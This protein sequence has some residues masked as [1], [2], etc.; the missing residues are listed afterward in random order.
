MK[1][2]LATI[3][4]LFAIAI[5]AFADEVQYKT[6]LEEAKNYE[7]NEQWVYAMGTYWDACSAS[8]YPEGAKE[9]Y[10]GFN[11]IAAG[12]SKIEYGPWDS[13]RNAG[14][15]GPGEYDI[16]TRY[17]GWIKVCKEFEIYWTEHSDEILY[18]S[19]LSCNEGVPDMKT[20]TITYNFRADVEQTPKFSTIWNLI[21]KSFCAAYQINWEKIPI[22]WPAVSMFH[23]SKTIPVVKF[24][25]EILMQTKERW[26]KDMDEYVIVGRK[27]NFDDHTLV[28]PAYEVTEYCVPAWNIKQLINDDGDAFPKQKITI[29]IDV[30]NNSESKWMTFDAAGSGRYY[31]S[32]PG[33]SPDIMKSMDRG[34]WIYEVESIVSKFERQIESSE[35][36][37]KKKTWINTFLVF[38]DNKTDELEI[39]MYKTENYRNALLEYEAVPL[40]HDMFDG[41]K[42]VKG[43][44]EIQILTSNIRNDYRDEYIATLAASDE[45]LL[46]PFTDKAKLSEL[47]GWTKIESGDKDYG[48]DDILELMNKMYSSKFYL[49]YNSETHKKC[50]Y[51][52]SMSAELRKLVELVEEENA[53][54]K[55]EEA[56]KKAEEALIGRLEG[57]NKIRKSAFKDDTSLSSLIIPSGITEIGA[58]AFFG[59][60]SLTSI[61][62]PSTVIKIGEL[63]F[64]ECSSLKDIYF[65]GT[66]AKWFA[67]YSFN[68]LLLY[69]KNIV[70][71]CSDGDINKK[72]Y[73]SLL[74]IEIPDGVTEICSS[75]F[76]YCHS[77]TS[78]TIPRSVKK[79]NE[80]AFASCINLKTVNYKGSKKEWNAIEINYNKFTD[81]PK[82]LKKAKINF[83]D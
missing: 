56:H 30:K 52:I 71:H 31:F 45:V 2:I 41:C 20:R 47:Y 22:Q 1:R 7:A 54:K 62:I 40:V 35:R 58:F 83:A 37:F 77:L 34:E 8:A 67:L 61:E 74:E 36:S 5:S 17:D 80:E 70:I 24:S 33:F 49:G 53:R 21:Y 38:E 4:V 18:V 6:L 60:S 57:T 39:K 25:P 50:I 79:I 28:F 81:N 32:V 65:D 29:R 14:N 46:I 27:N 72:V 51:C 42:M 44:Q 11:R 82:Y 9:A 78:I 55:Q 23:D 10:D 3:C 16:F 76:E 75:A 19:G 26:L 66:K 13:E 15:P 73:E 12:F 59:C 64:C 68:T 69:S 63:A 48:I 43:V